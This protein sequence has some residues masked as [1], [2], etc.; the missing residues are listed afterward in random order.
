MSVA[1]LFATWFGSGYSKIAPGTVGS[2]LTLPLYAVLVRGPATLYWAVTIGLT[3]FGVWAAERTA[4]ELGDEDPG[5]VVIDEV[6]GVLI[7]L[8]LA[9]GLGV[10]A[11]ALAFVLFRLFDIVKPG[12]VDWV[13]NLKP[14]G[15][16]IMADDVLAG[17]LAGLAVRAAFAFI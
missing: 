3:L 12:P 1:R 13:Q 11:L 14:P 6:V 15:L 8:G 2:V 4:Q 7:A 5:V 10:F 16:G 9:S 17:L